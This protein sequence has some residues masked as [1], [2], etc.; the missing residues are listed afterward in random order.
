[1]MK[2]TFYVDND[3]VNMVWKEVSKLPYIYEDK[4][5]PIVYPLTVEVVNEPV[6]VQ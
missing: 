1:M 6:Q 3:D 4:R 5:D 2:V